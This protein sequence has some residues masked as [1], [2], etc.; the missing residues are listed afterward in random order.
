MLNLLFISAGQIKEDRLLIF[1]GHFEFEFSLVLATRLKMLILW[2]N[3]RF[4]T[5]K[6]LGKCALLYIFTILIYIKGC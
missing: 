4:I 5:M 1:L 6:R 2:M 3:F